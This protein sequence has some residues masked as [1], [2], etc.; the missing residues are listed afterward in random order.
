LVFSTF[1]SAED[2]VAFHEKIKKAAPSQLSWL[3]AKSYS[4]III[5][6]SNLDLLKRNKQLEGYRKLLNEQYP[7]KF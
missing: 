1:E 5:T 3:S 6:Q 4:F 2:A 7:A